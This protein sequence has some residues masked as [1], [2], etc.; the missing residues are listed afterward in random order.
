LR[1]FPKGKRRRGGRR[2]KKKGAGEAEGTT[3][4][5]VTQN[6]ALDTDD[7]SGTDAGGDEAQTPKPRRKRSRRRR[8]NAERANDGGKPDA[9]DSKKAPADGDGGSDTASDTDERDAA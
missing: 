1:N 8:P 2:R 7:E 6:E 4:V 9:D 3:D 5:S